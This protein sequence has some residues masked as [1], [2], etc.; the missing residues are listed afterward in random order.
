ML[1][2]PARGADEFDWLIFEQSGVLTT[3]Q[4]TA[5]AGRGA[6]RGHLA[7]GRWRRVTKGILCAYNGQLAHDQHLWVAVLVAGTGAV[8]AGSTAL[9][10]AG[11]RGLPDDPIRVLVPAARNRTARLPR[12]P[13]DMPPVRVT[14]TRTL[15]VEHLQTG[16]PPRTTTAR[17]VIDAA[18][19]A[20][21]ADHAR[22]VL[23]AACQ[24]R[25]VTPDQVF[26][27][28]AMRQMLPRRSMIRSTLLDIV[29]GAHA[30]S[31]I[32]FAHL[33]RRFR[34]PKPDQQA[35]RT[36]GSGRV[37]YLDA[38]WKRWGLHVEVDGAHH[39]DVRQWADDMLRQNQIW[40]R[41]DRILRFPATLIRTRPAQVAGQLHAAL[42]AGGWNP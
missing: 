27:V 30:L 22:F 24:Q 21:T 37:R 31:E 2:L 6:V 3:A 26:E 1:A 42:E 28:L 41:G 38:Y 16:R 15:P 32:D 8:L 33:C 9:T 4:A 29:G 14:R 18:V 40:I 23:A 34:L 25:L 35:R 12:L 17:A 39:M 7:A 5:L 36:D 11:L 19:W 10:E 20:P 13:T